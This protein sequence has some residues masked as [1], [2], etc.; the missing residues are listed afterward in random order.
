MKQPKVDDPEKLR[1]KKDTADANACVRLISDLFPHVK[2]R[3]VLHGRKKHELGHLNHVMLT[4]PNV[5]NVCSPTLLI[6]DRQLWRKLPL[7][8]YSQV[9]ESYHRLLHHIIVAMLKNFHTIC[10]LSGAGISVSGSHLDSVQGAALRLWVG[11]WITK[12]LIVDDTS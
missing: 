9:L 1:P 10:R 6:Y 11:L 4:R 2:V 3:S 8:T 5:P 7:K 12:S